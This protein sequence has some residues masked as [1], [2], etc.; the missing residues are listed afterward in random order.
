MKSIHKM[1]VGISLVVQSI[2]MLIL[3]IA[4]A[5][6]RRGLSATFFGVSAASALVGAKLIID[7]KNEEDDDFFDIDDINFDEEF[8]DE[9]DDDSFTIDDD[10]VKVD[11][12]HGTDDEAQA[13]E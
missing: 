10:M 1:I 5:K 9:A 13:E 12:E 2:T 7:A 8:N 11:L 6:R 3:G 4:Q